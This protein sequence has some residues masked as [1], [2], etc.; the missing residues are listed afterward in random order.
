MKN[1]KIYPRF[2]FIRRSFV[3]YSFADLGD[4]FRLV[5]NPLPYDNLPNGEY[6]IR[7]NK[8]DHAKYYW[9]KDNKWFLT[10]DKIKDNGHFQCEAGTYQMFPSLPDKKYKELRKNYKY[11]SHVWQRYVYGYFH[12]KE[13]REIGRNTSFIRFKIIGK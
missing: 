6:Q 2:K 8:K 1:K 10:E 12:W 11:L 3:N 4:D 7:G 9:V 5:E 13:L